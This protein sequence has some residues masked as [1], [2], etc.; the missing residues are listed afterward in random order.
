MISVLGIFVL[1]FSLWKIRSRYFNEMQAK[2][3][4]LGLII[5]LL[6]TID[7]IF[8]A[9]I[10]V[11]ILFFATRETYRSKKFLDGLLSGFWT[12]LSSG[13]VACLTALLLIV[14]GMKYILLDPLNLKEWTDIKTSVIF[15]DMSVYFA[16]Q[17]FAGA[18]MHLFILGIIF[19]L[20][21]GSIGGLTGKILRILNK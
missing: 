6:W 20:I 8:W 16:Y 14:F 2:N 12:G 4:G 10:T 11:I 1:V 5:G 7:N 17:T 21:L 18:V 19:G 13:A 9:I 15:P 3:V